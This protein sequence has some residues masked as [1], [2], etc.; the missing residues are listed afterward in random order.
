MKK[1][2]KRSGPDSTKQPRSDFNW[3]PMEEELAPSGIDSSQSAHERLRAYFNWPADD[4]APPP[5]AAET[6][7]VGSEQPRSAFN[8]PPPDEVDASSGVGIIREPS[9]EE[10][11]FNWPPA[12][13]PAAAPVQETFEPWPA[14]VDRQLD[15]PVLPAT[16]IEAAE[17]PGVADSPTLEVETAEAAAVDVELDAVTDGQADVDVEFDA[18]TVGQWDVEIGRLQTL[19]E[20][21]TEKLE[22]RATGAIGNQQRLKH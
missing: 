19:I 7:T 9:R 12:D 8:W 20:G 18:L 17:Y 16:P 2:D 22:W 10:G 6:P 21:L 1:L 3:P 4:G 13:E 5:V 15:G 14:G 11:S